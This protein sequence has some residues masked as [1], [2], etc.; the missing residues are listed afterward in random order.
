MNKEQVIRDYGSL[1]LAYVG[2]AVYEILVREH[3]LK[4]GIT[5][6]GQMH[7]AAKRYVSAAAQSEILSRISEFL[8]EDEK[9]VIRR[10]RNVKSHS[11]PKNADL[12]DYHNATA[13]EALFG[14]LYLADDKERISQ[15]FDLIIGNEAN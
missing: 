9:G 14:Y 8:T 7:L 13:F 12:S 1:A 6:N 15:L 3:I 10:G 4:K 2:D 11:H 5:V